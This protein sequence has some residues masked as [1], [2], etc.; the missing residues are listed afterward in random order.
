LSASFDYK[1]QILSSMDYFNTD[2]LILYSDIPTR[3]Q[4]TIY[5]ILGNYFAYLCIVFLLIITLK[6]IRKTKI[7]S[8]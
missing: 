2:D 5:S 6:V 4:T 8:S 1:G 3:G 7:A